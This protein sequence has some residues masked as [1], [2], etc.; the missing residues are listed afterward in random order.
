MNQHN[1]SHNRRRNVKV[2]SPFLISQIDPSVFSRREFLISGLLSSAMLFIGSAAWAKDPEERV[3]VGFI[4]PDSGEMEQEAKSLMSGFDLFFDKDG[5]CPVDL[6]KKPFQS[7]SDGIEETLQKWINDGNVRFIVLFA[8]VESSEKAIRTFASAGTILFVANRSVKL[9]SGEVCNTNVF[10]VSANN[11]VLSEPLAPWAIKNCGTKV[12]I[13]GDNDRDANEKSDFFAFGFERAG[14]EFA[15]RVMSDGSD[16]SLQSVLKSIANSG[17]DFVFACF[18]GHSAENFLKAFSAQDPKSRKTVI[19]PETL[20]SF[21]VESGANREMILNVPTL[22]NVLNPESIKSKIVHLYG[23]MPSSITRVSEGHDLGQI[24]DILAKE[25]ILHT[26]DFETLLKYIADLK[27]NGLR[28]AFRFDKNHDAIVESW[29]TTREAR[30][31]G[32][33]SQKVLAT[34]GSSESL[35]FGCGKVGYSGNH[36]DSASSDADGVWEENGN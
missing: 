13:T 12:F 32:G 9:V 33:F 31:G 27:F 14:G 23:E 29:V 16:E 20:T 7:N 22:T 8:D 6:F 1:N 17:P 19:G 36:H 34:L 11:Y 25:Q 21:D 4:Y 24:I 30:P 35:D 3:K 26:K 10:R 18:K 2:E 15:D 5:P 28:G